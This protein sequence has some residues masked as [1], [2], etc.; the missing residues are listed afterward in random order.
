MKKLFC[1]FGLSALLLTSCSSGDS[2]S[3]S[4]ESDVLVKKTVETYALDGSTVTTN[5]TYNG[6]KLVKSTDSDGY[7]DDYTYTG[8]LITKIATID[9]SDGTLIQEQ[10]FTYNVSSQLATYVIKD[11]DSDEGN[12]ET[13]VYN[14]NGTVSITTYVGNTTTQTVALSTGTVHFTGGLVTQVDLD[15]NDVAPYTST[16]T[17]TYDTKNGPFKN[18]TGMDKFS[19]IGGESGD[20][21]HNVLTDHYTSTLSSDVDTITTYT[22]NSMNFPISDSEIEGTD[23]TSVI[24]TQYT[25]N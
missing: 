5:Y 1:L 2:A 21:V 23:A 25:Y 16:Q 17:Y 19:F 9:D 6:K 14:S 20:V 10:I 24:A 12:R 3:T 4:T 22:Y 7:H 13:Y 15:V 11:Y 8:D 18:V